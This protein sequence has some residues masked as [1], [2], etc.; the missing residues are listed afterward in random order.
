M[1]EAAAADRGERTCC[2][3]NP[4]P[5]DFQVLPDGRLLVL[6]FGA[7]AR[8]PEGLPAVVGD[9][10]ARCRTGTTTSSP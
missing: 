7:V 8:L 5:G 9:D 1:L 3:C 6:D 2:R 10:P 4:H